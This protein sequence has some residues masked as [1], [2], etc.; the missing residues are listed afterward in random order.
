MKIE[1]MKTKKNLKISFNEKDV[2]S[3]LLEKEKELETLKWFDYRRMNP[4]SS[5][6]LFFLVYLKIYK[7]FYAKEFDVETAVD[8][9]PDFCDE[10]GNV[11]LAT[12]L[13]FWVARQSA[14]SIGCRYEHYIRTAFKRVYEFGWSYLPSPEQLSTMDCVMDVKDNWEEW[15]IHSLQLAHSDWYSAKSYCGSPEQNAYHEYLV[16][17]C[18]LRKQPLYTISR[19]VYQEKLIP[20]N[21]AETLFSK[22]ELERALEIFI[23]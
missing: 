20:V 15:K 13:L 5:T 8:A 14:D 18:R 21:I 10:E 22:E 9:L 3:H 19:V 16:E 23:Q 11:T 1:K 4:V 2:P 17:Q 6:S 7:E 12:R